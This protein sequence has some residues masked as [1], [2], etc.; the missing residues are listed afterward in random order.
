MTAAPILE[1]DGY[2]VSFSTERGSLRVL[3]DIHLTIARGEILGLVG[4]SGSGKSTLAYAVMRAIGADIVS[5]VGHIRLT[6]NS[7]I[8]LD[9]RSL[10]A[11]RGNRVAMVFQD[12]GAS[13][14]PTLTIAEHFRQVLARH[15]AL[16]SDACVAETNR[17]LTM[18]GL[19]DPSLAMAKFAHE[20]SGGEK[21]RAVIAMAFACDPDLIL[22]DEPTS[23]LDATTAVNILDL[24]RTLQIE[25]GVAALFISHDLGVVSEIAH[26]VAVIYAGRIVE[27]A[28]T[29]ALFGDPRHPYT[30]A[31]LRSLPSPRVDDRENALRDIPGVLPDRITPMSGCQFAPRCTQAIDKCRQ[32][33][34]SLNFKGNRALACIVLS[35]LDVLDDG[36]AMTPPAVVSRG[37]TSTEPG[38]T[39]GSSTDG[40]SSDGSSTTQPLGEQTILQI[41]DLSVRIARPDFFG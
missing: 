16:A 17:L 14:N 1:V 12:A 3:D 35:L 18:V 20:L 41:E 33:D 2:S 29:D 37:E 15:R 11:L 22:F 25:T 10:S 27:I 9:E 7:L 23:A 4:E 6:G 40:A 31:L 30:Q 36:S 21:Q 39:G 32:E 19:A 5:E 26:R 8:G 38:S 13:L 28:E 34:V 24:F